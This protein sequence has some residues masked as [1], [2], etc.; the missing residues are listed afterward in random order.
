VHI[1]FGLGTVAVATAAACVVAT[2]GPA[3]AATWTGKDAPNDMGYI[4][5]IQSVRIVHTANVVRVTIRH[6]DL[7]RSGVAG[8]GIYFDTDPRRRGPEYVL[9]SG[10]YDRTDHALFRTRPN[11]KSS[12]V[13][14]EDCGVRVRLN[15]AKDTSVFTTSDDCFG[16]PARVRV[17]VRV[18][19]TE[20]VGADKEDWLMGKRRFTRWIAQD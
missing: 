15:F 10:L 16:N 4:A 3:T 19:T 2:A 13:M 12:G 14:V 7:T 9:G 17:A 6:K 20:D 5:D 18:S 1:P 11:W 8:A